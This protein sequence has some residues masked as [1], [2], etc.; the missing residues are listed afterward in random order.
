MQK[1]SLRTEKALIAQAKQLIL[2]PSK[3]EASD[4]DVLNY[5]SWLSARM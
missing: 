5:K 1:E 4:A 2:A 3:K